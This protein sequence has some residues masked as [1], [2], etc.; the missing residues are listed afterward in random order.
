M[1]VRDVGSPESTD[2]SL[3][4]NGS[5]CGGT[6]RRRNLLLEAFYKQ[7]TYERLCINWEGW[8]VPGKNGA[9]ETRQHNTVYVE[10]SCVGCNSSAVFGHARVVSGGFKRN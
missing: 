5:I 1:H 6:K 8:K 3:K 9:A 2:S 10:S 4:S 7:K